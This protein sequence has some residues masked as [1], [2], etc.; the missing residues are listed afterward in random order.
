MQLRLV[1]GKGVPALSAAEFLHSFDINHDTGLPL[2]MLN[3]GLSCFY[4]S[5][6]RTNTAQAER[7]EQG[8]EVDCGPRRG[9]FSV[10]FYGST[11]V[12]MHPRQ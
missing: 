4:G 8:S 12:V 2:W 1:V 3:A 9:A 5:P 7:G 10:M 6:E 11:F